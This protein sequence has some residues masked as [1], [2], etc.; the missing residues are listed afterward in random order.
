MAPILQSF[1]E[2]KAYMTEIV[3]N[4]SS[5]KFDL[6]ET[7]NGGTDQPDGG[8]VFTN[9]F[10]VVDTADKAEM[11]DTNINAEEID[12][13]DMDI[14]EIVKTLNNPELNLSEDLI[15][16]IKN[17]LKDLFDKIKL[18]NTGVDSVE[19]EQLN[20]SVNGSFVYIMKF[21]EELESLITSSQNGNDITQ[22]LETILDQVRTKLNERVKA[23]IEKKIKAKYITKNDTKVVPQDQ[24]NNLVNNKQSLHNEGNKGLFE[25]S[26]NGTEL[27][28]SN[29]N[30]KENATKVDPQKKLSSKNLSLNN[31]QSSEK[32]SDEPKDLGKKVSQLKTDTLTQTSINSG[33]SKNLNLESNL[34]KQPLN[35][36]NKLDT[37]SNFVEA[38]MQKPSL[39]NQENNDK[40]LQNLNMLSKNWGTKLIEKIEKSIV[41]GFEKIEISL[42]PKS[43][44][45]LNVTIN[46][47]DTIAKISITAESA[48]AAA[49]LADAGSKLS[50]M[51]EFSGL[52]LASLQTQAHQFG[53]NQKGREHARKL[54][55]TTKKT[56]IDESSKPIENI[57]KIKIT[58]E[59]LNLIA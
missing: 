32:K 30:L 42:T 24:K 5:I 56:N 3:K 58:N 51:M 7:G 37:V 44:G 17:R 26:P 52:K 22:K 35:F 18:G 49:L 20:N 19:S 29:L 59:G 38:N 6:L 57:N 34:L 8:G 55:S 10:G 2:E 28:K 12:Y 31:S 43:L 46:M 15:A 21:L 39:F 40:L 54:A 13:A 53:G 1:L 14:M 36:T 4:N 33:L 50:Q 45:R 11:T 41:D 9:L 25:T 48:N 16:D 23:F 47:Q 27:K